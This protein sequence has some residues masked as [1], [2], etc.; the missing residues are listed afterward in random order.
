MPRKNTRTYDNATSSQDST[1]NGNQN[2]QT[3]TNKDKRSP[4]VYVAIAA[5]VI[6]VI[7]IAY[8]A[9]YG[10]GGQ[11]LNAKQILSN[12]SNSNLNQT[13]ARFVN[14]LKRSE[15]VSNLYVSYYSNNA[16]EYVTESSNLTIAISTNQTLDSYKMGDYN[17]S[18]L[19]T[20]VD[21]TDSKNGDVIEKNISSIYYYKTN[22][23]V[24]C[25]NDTVYTS[26]P[27][28][29]SSLACANGDQGL[30]F[31]EQ[32]PFTAANVS[33]LST[34][35]FNS[36]ISYGGI[37]TIAGRSCDSFIISN[38]T[39]ANLQSNYSVYGMC[40]DTQYGILLYLN[41]TDVVGGAPSSFTFTAT[42]VSTD[43]SGSE[44]VIPQQYL[45]AIPKSII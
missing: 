19:T 45:S 42:A 18:A 17:R 37:K 15:N 43:V 3:T 23:T 34:L 30:S 40:V 12:V 22:V 32:T 26:G 36:T 39:T 44:L 2:A 7:A 6:V 14:D 8:Y 16:T 11:S 35:I 13:Q 1:D 38:A 29:N 27:L 24:T 20:I 21:Y 33:G 41:Q 31:L 5:I 28:T 9:L 25:F 10:S 4:L